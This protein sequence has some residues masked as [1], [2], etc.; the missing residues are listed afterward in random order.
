MGVGAT[1]LAYH[2][3]PQLPLALAAG[4][5]GAGLAFTRPMAGLG[6]ALA[7]IPFEVFNVSVGGGGLSPTEMMLALTAIGWLSGRLVRGQL[8]WTPSP[9]GK[10]LG[11]LI[12][13]MVPGIAIAPS[14]F[15]VVKPLAFW[16]LFFLVYQMIVAEATPET[17]GWL[18]LVLVIAAA[19]VGLVTIVQS[20]GTQQQVVGYGDVVNGR[21][22]GTFQQPNTL[23]SFEALALPAALAIGLGASRPWLR[24][25]GLAAFGAILAAI[26]LSLSRGGF[27]AVAGALA[28]MLVWRPFRRATLAAVAILLV[29]VFSGAAHLGTVQ[30]VNIVGERLSSVGYSA[31]GVDPRF[32]IWAQVPAMFRDHWAIGAGENEFSAIAPDYGL[33]NLN[34]TGTFDHAHNTFF[35]IAIELGVVGLA[36][37]LWLGVALVRVSARAISRTRGSARG[38]AFALAAGFFAVVVQGMVDYTLRS[39]VIAGTLFVLAGCQVVLSRVEREEPLEAPRPA[40]W[41]ER[42]AVARAAS[43][44]SPSSP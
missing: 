1:L 15:T 10:P 20:G 30:Q 23:A 2:S 5:F 16:I 42:L 3:T 7:L 29:F 8:P 34:A 6:F 37:L 32:A 9:L 35:T 14:A 38:M 24:P 21:A 12:L 22:T 41:R 36:A 44:I 17:I 11:L 39:N 26:V 18:L 25:V 43:Q 13:A 31:E 4:I 27:L 28:V 33:V 19:V 40:S